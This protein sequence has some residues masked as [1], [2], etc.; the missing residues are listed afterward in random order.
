LPLPG[1]TVR[2]ALDSAL[3]A[4]TA[5]RL[6]TPR[7]DA[8]VLLAHALGADRAALYTDPARELSGEAA[9]AFQT[10]VRRRA[11]D[12]V[13]V[14]YL[15]G[16]KGFRH[17]ELDVDE[18]VLVPR[19]ETE[20]LVEAAV[21]LLPPGARVVDVGAG[22]GAV[23]LALKHERPDLDV[24]A[25][26]VSED[27]LA[28]ARANAERL[29]LEVA[30]ARHD[31][32]AGTPDAVVA[33]PPYIAEGDALPP[34]VARHE[35]AVALFGG[36]DG[37]DVVRRLVARCAETGVPFLAMEIGEGQADT[38]AAL[39]SG[40]AFAHVETRRDLAG[41]ERVVVCRR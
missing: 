16:R 13:P 4:L 24:A 26:D 40:A 12:R 17:L 11:V 3:V 37:L 23:A 5:A 29:G 7:L 18:R 39:A 20:V 31:L 1:T 14:A 25:T 10:L 32:F 15:V 21:E 2:D 19:P 36:P 30:F 6:D 9:R 34:E 38:V 27:A 33:N 22:S 8:E 28:V 41:I 35:P